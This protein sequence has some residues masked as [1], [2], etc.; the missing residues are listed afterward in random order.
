MMLYEYEVVFSY[1]S[2]FIGTVVTVD[3]LSKSLA[4]SVAARH[5][6]ELNGIDIDMDKC[7]TVKAAHTGTIG[8]N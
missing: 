5:I 7:E 6:W 1:E 3:K 2:I 8:G 4:M